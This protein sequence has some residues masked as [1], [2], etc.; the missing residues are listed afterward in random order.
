MSM[1]QFSVEA[2]A[3]SSVKPMTEKRRQCPIRLRPGPLP[4]QP[5]L[6]GGL[7]GTS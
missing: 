7:T 2:G 5:V 4:P 1:V 6:E 3:S